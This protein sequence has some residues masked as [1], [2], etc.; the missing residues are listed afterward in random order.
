MS[1]NIYFVL[2]DLLFISVICTEYNDKL[3][4]IEKLD[5]SENA[6]DCKNGINDKLKE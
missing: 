2:F 3:S 4:F 6:M 5:N 1:F